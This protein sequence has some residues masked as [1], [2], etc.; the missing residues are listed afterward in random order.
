M[1]FVDH[2]TARLA[3]LV[4]ERWQL[5]AGRVTAMAAAHGSPGLGEGRGPD[6]GATVTIELSGVD[7]D[8]LSGLARL[9][10][11]MPV[12]P[13]V[14]SGGDRAVQLDRVRLN[15]AAQ[16]SDSLLRELLTW[17]NVHVIAVRPGGEDGR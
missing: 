10:G 9:P 17:D 15:V 13:E 1:L 6:S 16:A 5:E 14:V 4:D 8:S 2:D 7:A 3:G 12:S 11:V